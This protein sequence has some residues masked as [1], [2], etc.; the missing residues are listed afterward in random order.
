[1]TTTTDGGDVE[2]FS[3]NA[4]V[5]IHASRVRNTA[6]CGQQIIHGHRLS[7]PAEL[8]DGDVTCLDC[9]Q[10]LR[11]AGYWK[12]QEAPEPAEGVKAD[13]GK[14]RW[15]LV[16]WAG[17][18]EVVHVLTHGAAKYAPD[19]WKKVPDHR[20]RYLSAALRHMTAWALGEIRDAESG[21]PHLA[22]AVCCL[23]FLIE[24]EGEKP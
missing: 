15:D 1:M 13:A 5:I 12:Y 6:D 24:R 9:R 2:Y 14:A 10:G 21:R 8:C 20:R 11:N 16:P 3:G 4:P 23:L 18:T 19:N 22:H 17:M 7:T